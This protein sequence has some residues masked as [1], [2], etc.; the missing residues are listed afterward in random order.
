MKFRLLVSDALAYP[1]RR[2]TFKYAAP[3]TASATSCAAPT[4][5]FGISFAAAAKRQELIARHDLEN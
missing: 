3:S 1:Y 2:F 5:W 4:A